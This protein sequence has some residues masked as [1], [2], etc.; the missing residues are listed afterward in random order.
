MMAARMALGKFSNKGPAKSNTHNSRN[1]EMKEAIMVFPPELTWTNVLDMEAVIGSDMKKQP[2]TLEAPI[3]TNS[4][5]AS[6]V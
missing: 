6:T 3:A 4:W 2:N 5:L 1:T